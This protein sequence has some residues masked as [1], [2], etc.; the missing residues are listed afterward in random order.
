[1]QVSGTTRVFMVVGDPISQVQAPQVFN[2][3]FRRH[4]VDAVLVPAHVHPEQV[5]LFARHVLQAE[6]I[7]GLWVTIPH[8]PA[9]ASLVDRCNPAGTIA[10]SVNAVRRD[11][12]GS[13]HGALFDGNGF[14]K[15]LRHFGFDPFGRSALVVGAGGAGAAIAA[16]L[17]DAGLRHLA[18]HDLGERA[19][20]LASRLAAHAASTRVTSASA[21]PAGFDLVVNAT[22]LGLKP[23]APLPFDVERLDAQ[24]TV[25]DILMKSEP[26]PLLRAC[27]TRDID[28]HPGFE[29]LV[30][31]VPDYLDFFGLHDAARAVQADLSE[32]RE[33]LLA[34]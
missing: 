13:L 5:A 10:Q 4:G 12:D 31:Q 8:K 28:A 30:Q 33:L 24:A 29:M 20:R 32:V 25:V 19:A 11:S 15:A 21:D 23:G 6:N 17:I 16:S 1:M 9:M 2:H 27:R 14:V 7:D 22:P 3:L 26:T 34:Q 18:L